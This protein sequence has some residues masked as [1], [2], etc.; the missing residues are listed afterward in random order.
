MSTIFEGLDV[1]D[2]DEVIDIAGFEFN[3]FI[4]DIGNFN[5]SSKDNVEV[6]VIVTCNFA[7]KDTGSDFTSE[8]GHRT[9]A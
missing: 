7:G 2:S 9:C 3:D 6:E 4:N 8:Q 1:D 5:F